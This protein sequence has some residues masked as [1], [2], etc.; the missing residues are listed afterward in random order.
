ME[1]WI[2]RYEEVQEMRINH[3]AT[4]AQIRRAE[5]HLCELL[6]LEAYLALMELS[7]KELSR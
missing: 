3:I 6:K 7:Y 2:T 4:P 5:N 1:T